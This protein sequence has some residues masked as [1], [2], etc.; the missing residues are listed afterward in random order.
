VEVALRQ[1]DPAAEISIMMMKMISTVRETQTDLVSLQ[2]HFT[3]VHLK[4]GD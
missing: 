3:I 4:Y 1:E 2:H